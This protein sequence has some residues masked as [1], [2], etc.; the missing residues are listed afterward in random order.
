MVYGQNRRE[1][2]CSACGRFIG[3]WERC[4]FCRHFNPKRWPVRLIKYS[5]P[6][7]TVVGLFLLAAMGRQYGVQPVQIKDLSRKSN[8][9]QVRLAG[10]ISDEIRFHAKDEEGAG[11]S[12]EF[13]LDDGTDVIRVR[14]YDDVTDELRRAGKIPGVGDQVVVDGS[15]QYKA[16][17]HF[18][19]LGS[20]DALQIVREKP[21]TATPIAWLRN[22]EEKGLAAGQRLK[23]TGRIE[24]AKDGPYDRRL[25]LVDPAGAG[26][27][28]SISSGLLDAHGAAHPA[29]VYVAALKVGDVVTCCGSLAQTKGRAR[30]WQLAPA[31]P[32]DFAAADES[33]WRNDNAN[34]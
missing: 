14:A 31:A 7:L 23:V 21:A 28:I 1:T 10:R 29:A 34:R 27:A 32:D 18:I 13:D 17:R 16:R 25:W 2:E 3:S 26:I 11:G 5:M 9:A 12:L 22:P 8:Y 20:A 6:V 4:P 30:T 24:D 19:I 33:T 15:Y